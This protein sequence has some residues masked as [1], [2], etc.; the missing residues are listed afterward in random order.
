MILG[1]ETKFEKI[2]SNP[3]EKLKTKI[4]QIVDSVNAVQDQIHLDRLTGHFS[5]GYIYGNPK[6]HKDSENPPLRPIISQVG[7]PTY[8][9]A[10]KLNEIIIEYLPQEH[11][12]KNREELLQILRTSRPEGIL[13]SLDVESLFTNVP[14]DATIDIILQNTYNHDTR[15]PPKIPRKSLETLLRVC[16]TEAPFQHIDGSLYRQKEGVAMGSPLGPTF[17]NFYMANVEKEVLQNEVLRPAIYTRYVDD[18]FVV[19]RDEE[20][21]KQLQSSLQEKSVLNFT[22]EIGNNKL[23]FL[24]V[25]IETSDDKYNTSVYVKKTNTG[26][27]LNYKSECPEKY[28]VSVINTFLHR[29]YSVSQDWQQF[30]SEIKR[31]KQ[32]LINNGY[33][34]TVIDD[35]IRRYI[36]S[37]MSRVEIANGTTHKLFYQNQMTPQYKIDERVLK[38][39]FQEKITCRDPNAKVVLNIYYKNK[40]V[41]NLLMK[42]NV[43]ASN[44]LL[45]MSNVVYK[46]KCPVGS[47]ESLNPYYIGYTECTVA[48]R[49]TFHAQ[50]GGPKE[51]CRKKHNILVSRDQL[52]KNTTIITSLPDVS[53]LKIYEALTI[54]SSRPSLNRQHEVFN[55]VLKLHH[56]SP[57]SE[58]PVQQNRPQPTI[59]ATNV[60]PNDNTEQQ[61]PNRTVPEAHQTVEQEPSAPYVRRLRPRT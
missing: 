25:L 19:V 57:H 21:L 10:K 35:T 12:I 28:K 2:R 46:I 39:I 32:L 26:E 45:Q 54:L 58:Q 1:D 4:N 53:R 15:P 52:I 6:I 17:A 56:S 49:M 44:E 20:H 30:H 18:I 55:N 29:A 61:P 22:Y 50:D 48:K 27:C 9:L 51:H 31:V 38:T 60:L 8:K 33:P 5:P 40:K 14:I 7:T 34:L 41:S 16:T 24:D 36:D 3:V 43:N 11:S 37:K 13:A 23:P 42:N 59:E 47:C